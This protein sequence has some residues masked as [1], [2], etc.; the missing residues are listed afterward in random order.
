MDK[1]LR[2]LTEWLSGHIGFIACL[3]AWSIIDRPLLWLF[4]KIV[5]FSAARLGKDNLDLARISSF[6]MSALSPTVWCLVMENWTMYD[7][8]NSTAHGLIQLLMNLTF[9]AL[10]GKNSHDKR[11]SGALVKNIDTEIF[12]SIYRFFPFIPIP[13]IIASLPIPESKAGELAAGLLYMFSMGIVAYLISCDKPPK[14]DVHPVAELR[15]RIAQ[16]GKPNLEPSR[17]PS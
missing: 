6:V 9:I 13:S 11:T 2:G 15:R 1:A 5:D 17:V 3:L 10:M 7:F 12:L 14:A 4:Q 8:I 16:L